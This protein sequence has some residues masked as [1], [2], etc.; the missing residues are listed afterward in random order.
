VRILL[1]AA[2]SGFGPVAKLTAVSRAL[3]PH[4]RTF[5]GATV[6]AEFAQRNADAFDD[7]IDTGADPGALERALAGSDHV[8][9]VMDADLV[10]RAFAA[11]RPV[12]FVDS[13]FAFWRLPSGA[14]HVVEACRQVR[15]DGPGSLE[16][17]LGGLSPHE[18]K[19]AGHVLA[20]ISAAQNFPGVRER[21]EE[22]RSLGVE[23]IHVTGS[24]VDEPA[25]AEGTS[26]P[27]EPVDLL[28]GLG[29][30]KNFLLDYEHHNEYL[31]LFTRWVPDLLA[32]WPRF[33]RVLV[34]GGGYADNRRRT[35]TVGTRSAAL[36]CL[37][38]RSFV[39][40]LASARHCLLTP[41]LTAI[42]EATL[43]RRLPMGL[44]EQHY[45]HI[46]NLRSLRGTVFEETA[47][48]FADLIDGY[49]V[50]A[51]DYKG[52]TAIIA[53]VGRLLED[54]DA[55]RRFRRG[56]NER[57][58]AFLA[59]G[60]GPVSSGVAQLR[61]LFDGPSFTDLLARVFRAPATAEHA[62]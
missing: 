51:H 25:I 8:V 11:G 31:R 37:P 13:L 7:I 55:Y 21:V 53:Q 60:P 30:F 29:G 18:R 14:A 57:I 20:D 45:G 10:F 1:G 42:H 62:R 54:D 24:I 48:R 15:R 32:D 35:V 5:A 34:A 23:R 28:L 4:H 26:T 2:S 38:H 61:A 40:E 39:R 44:P 43:L 49:S 46:V 12:M 52:T 47:A 33:E 56:L 17:H 59:L 22:A 16:R 6:A 27:H 3:A 19:Y 9:A 36:R 41:G 50:P 58:E